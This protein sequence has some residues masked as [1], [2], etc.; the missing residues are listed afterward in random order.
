[1]ILLGDSWGSDV[2]PPVCVGMRAVWL[3]RYGL[4][5]LNPQIAREIT[6]IVNVE[7]ELFF[8][9]KF[10]LNNK[11]MSAWMKAKEFARTIGISFK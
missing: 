11:I 2:L 4:K 6:S 5:C 1:M 9:C 8:T 3:N 10:T 7:T